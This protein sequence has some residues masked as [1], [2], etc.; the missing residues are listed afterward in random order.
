MN[1]IFKD[2]IQQNK[3]NILEIKN[4]FKEEPLS[5]FPY[6]KSLLFVC[7]LMPLSIGMYFYA[8]HQYTKAKKAFDKFYQN[9]DEKMFYLY[10][11]ENQT[12]YLI[13][14]DKKVFAY[15]TDTS[16]LMTP[17]KN[18]IIL[19]RP[20]I[21]LREVF[22]LNK[23]TK[24]DLRIMG[25]IS[26]S[27]QNPMTVE[28][29]IELFNQY[30]LNQ[31]EEMTNVLDIYQEQKVLEHVIKTPTKAKTLKHNSGKI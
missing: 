5:S 8:T 13:T 1:A 15:F 11:N 2:L 6:V 25:R 19:H 10:H 29:V 17:L 7:V 31:T 9:G 30:H 3:K 24:N 28:K 26:D 12:S 21:T 22:T 4:D 18:S 14:P 27:L 20:T 23:E 16:N